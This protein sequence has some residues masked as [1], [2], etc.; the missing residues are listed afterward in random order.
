MTAM[1]DQ[2][3]DV[4]MCQDINKGRLFLKPNQNLDKIQVILTQFLRAE[5][6]YRFQALRRVR[7][8]NLSLRYKGLEH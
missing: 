5:T 1:A 2:S 7:H 6:L 8:G 3:S 4:L